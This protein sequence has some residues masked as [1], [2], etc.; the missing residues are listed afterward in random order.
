MGMIGVDNLK[1]TKMARK[2]VIPSVEKEVDFLDNS[3]YHFER[4]SGARRFLEKLE[5]NIN[6]II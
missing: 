2:Y 5:K 4:E 1:E 6:R 3:V